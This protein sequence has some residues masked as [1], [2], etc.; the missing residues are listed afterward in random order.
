[1]LRQLDSRLAQL[2]SLLTITYGVHGVMFREE[3]DSEFQENF[4]WVCSDLA[5][6]SQDLLSAVCAMQRVEGEAK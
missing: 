6:E 3:L 1:M 5:S 4:M 2:A